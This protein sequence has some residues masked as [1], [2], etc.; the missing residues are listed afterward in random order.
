MGKHNFRSKVDSLGITQLHPPI[1]LLC[2]NIKFYRH[3]SVTM[4]RRNFLST[5]AFLVLL[6]RYPY[7][8]AWSPQLP[9]NIS[10]RGAF[11]KLASLAAGIVTATKMDA[12]RASIAAEDNAALSKNVRLPRSPDSESSSFDGKVRRQ[13]RFVTV[14]QSS[15][16]FRKLTL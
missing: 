7:V 12:P 2:R 15:L 1:L 13:E 14:A 3:P 4:N 9:E 16:S 10:R 6:H 11:E 8:K 5:V